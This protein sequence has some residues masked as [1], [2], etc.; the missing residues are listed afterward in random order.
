MR[1]RFAVVLV[2]LL[3]A[4]LVMAQETRVAADI[5][6]QFQICQE[7]RS[8]GEWTIARISSV[9]V[10][11]LQI[12]NG[13]GVNPMLVRG[14]PIYRDL[15]RAAEAMLVFNRYGDRYYLSEVWGHG[16]V[17]TYLVPCQEEKALRLAGVKVERTVTYARLK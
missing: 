14:H 17:G 7:V 11:V 12:T 5:P 10:P 13:S 2:A 1:G 8:A 4:P 15:S 3:G 9:G 6:F 16:L